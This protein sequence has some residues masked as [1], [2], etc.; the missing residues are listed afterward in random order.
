VK[1][2]LNS[3]RDEDPKVRETAFLVVEKLEEPLGMLIHGTL[4]GSRDAGNELV[5]RKDPRS[6][7]P[8]IRL[9]RNRHGQVRRAATTVLGKI[10]DPRAIDGPVVTAG[11]WSL[12]DRFVATETL[13]EIDQKFFPIFWA[14]SSGSWPVLRAWGISSVS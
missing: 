7:G 1:P 8:L 12:R 14:P 3:K 10:R 5:R 9:L 4:A 11:G 2:L 13:Q 6:V